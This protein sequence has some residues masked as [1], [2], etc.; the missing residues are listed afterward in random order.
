MTA[1]EDR[2]DSSKKFREFV[3]KMVPLL[4]SEDDVAGMQERRNRTAHETG[5]P[6]EEVIDEDTMVKAD[7]ESLR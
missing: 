6:V 4:V 5:C 2:K 1:T 7:D 3:K